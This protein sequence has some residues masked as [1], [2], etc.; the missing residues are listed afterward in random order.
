MNPMMLVVTNRVCRRLAGIVLACLSTSWTGV[1]LAAAL[2]EAV[3]DD[4]L[5]GVVA[6]ALG[7]YEIDV[8]TNLNARDVMRE[9]LDAPRLGRLP[10]IPVNRLPDSTALM[11]W[12][13]AYTQSEV[14]G[15]AVF[16]RA[17]SE[18]GLPQAD[19]VTRWLDGA[20]QE[21]VFITFH[22]DDLVTV[23]AIERVMEG[24]GYPSLLLMEPAPPQ[25]AGELYA[26]A[27]QRLVLDSRG[28]RRYRSD[29]P[30]IAFLG[31]RVR[32]DSNSLFRPDGNR[33]DSSLARG[34]PA[35]FLKETLGDEFNQSTIREIVV[36]GGVALG[37]TGQLSFEPTQLRYAGSALTLIDGAGRTWQLPAADSKTLKALFDFV[38]RSNAIG[39]DAIVDI[40]GDGR[41]RIASALR[42]TDAGFAIMDADTQPFSFVRNLD[43]TKSVIIDTGARWFAGTEANSLTFTTAFEVRFLSA[44]NMRIAQTRAALEYDYEEETGQAAFNDTWGRDARRLHEDLDYSGLGSSVAVVAHYAGWI[45]LFRALEESSVPFVHGRYA[46]MK[47]DKTGRSTPARY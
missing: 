44:D 13:A 21:R 43:V 40:D 45:A 19:F 26:T 3:A 30:E 20:P 25:L 1:T 46:F 36:P 17:N 12:E 10:D 11:G 35:V 29:I 39:S 15:L 23:S 33:G 31:E 34:E 37:E 8:S 27:A 18:R 47:I 38:S 4:A 6:E 32:R 28:A 2:D 22:A 5:L 14:G 9:R 7:A 24:Y 41:V 42:D 16:A